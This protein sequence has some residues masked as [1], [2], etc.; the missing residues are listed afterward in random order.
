[1]PNP[2]SLTGDWDQN[3]TNLYEIFE[4]DLKHQRCELR[5]RRIVFDGRIIEDFREEGFWHLITK[6]DQGTKERL[7]DPRR[8]ECLPWFRPI[9]SNCDD[10]A[11]KVWNWKEGNGKI[12]TYIWLEEFDYV[13]ILQ[14]KRHAYYLV[15]AHHVDGE[16]T[17]RKLQAKYDGREP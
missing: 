17:R 9:L 4:A 15:T 16:G 5:G 14:G 1:L 13:I 6:I 11:V 7:F 10:D 12:R 8:A 3:L 2:F